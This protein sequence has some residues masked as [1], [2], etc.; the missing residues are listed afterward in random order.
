MKRKDG[1]LSFFGQLRMEKGL[2]DFG[3]FISVRD[4]QPD[5]PGSSAAPLENAPL[6]LNPINNVRAE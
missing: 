2:T 6:V 4:R 1:N 5:R 3:F